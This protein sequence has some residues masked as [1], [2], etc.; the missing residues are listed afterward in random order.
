M[1]ERELSKSNFLYILSCLDE[2]QD[3]NEIF[4]Y[5][6]YEHFYVIYTKFWELDE[7]GDNLLKYED[8]SL[9]PKVIER[10]IG[11]SAKKMKERDATNECE[12]RRMDYEDFVMFIISEE[13]K[14]NSQSIN[15]WFRIL[16]LD[17][18]GIISPYELELFFEEQSAKLFKVC[19]ETLS[20]ETILITLND[21][22]KP[23]EPYIFTLRDIKKSGMSSMFFNTI[24]NINKFAKGEEKDLTLINQIRESPHMTDWDR[25]A[26]TQYFELSTA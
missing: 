1:G 7:D 21:M 13:D 14:T 18:D 20:F 2:E 23:K 15:Y 12:K 25:F 3:I 17:G 11:G 26:S 10:I 4:E 16:D 6:S 5:F 8:Y 19:G 9:T 24:T 22:I